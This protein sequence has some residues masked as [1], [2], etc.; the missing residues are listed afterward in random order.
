MTLYLLRG[1]YAR[2]HL[3]K[4]IDSNSSYI[5]GAPIP[6]S[7]SCVQSLRDYKLCHMYD[8]RYQ[9]F[10]YISTSGSLVNEPR[11]CNVKHLKI[12]SLWLCIYF[13]VCQIRHFF[14]L[15]FSSIGCKTM[16]MRN[17]CQNQQ[18]KKLK[19]ISNH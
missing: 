14:H 13:Y 19:E 12:L 9:L 16:S 7:T 8:V 2:D 11:T 18:H 10:F 3:E 1:K 15:L 4:P 5:L 17:H 6:I